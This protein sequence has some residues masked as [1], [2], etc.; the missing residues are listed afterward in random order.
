MPPPYINEPPPRS[1]QEDVDRVRASLPERYRDVPD[2]THVTGLNEPFPPP[3]PREVTDEEMIELG[4]MERPPEPPPPPVPEPGA[5]GAAPDLSNIDPAQLAGLLQALAQVR[6][7]PLDLSHEP[8]SL[9]HLSLA[10]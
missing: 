5:A 3:P 7:P 6:P 4:L 1:K 8:L 2:F 9:S 10:L